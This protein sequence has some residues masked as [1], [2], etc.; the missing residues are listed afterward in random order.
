MD[1]ASNAHKWLSAG[2]TVVNDLIL[3]DYR[4]LGMSTTQF[5]VY[6]ELKSYLDKGI[7]S[8][9]INLIAEHLGSEPAQIYE[10]MHEMI[11]QKLMTHDTTTDAYGKQSESYSFDNLI[12]RVLGLEQAEV[13]KQTRAEVENQ[14]EQVFNKI[15][16]EFGRPLTP[17]EMEV[18]AKWIDEENYSMNL[19]TQALQEAVMNQAWSLKYMD[20]I[21]SSWDRQ[22][23][24]TVQQVEQLQAN[25]F[26]A[27]QK[28]KGETKSKT[29][30]PKI[31]IYK[32][33]QQD[34]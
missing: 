1:K 28:A 11:Q 5:M 10:I 31:P 19:I 27:K 13:T 6:L 29:P 30:K 18:V 15:E 12:L 20:R 26:E 21:L 9:D 7:V 16:V 32:I 8:P 17:M 3:H 33:S 34:E 22:N 24:R 23:I 4:K 25:R 14:R 2:Q